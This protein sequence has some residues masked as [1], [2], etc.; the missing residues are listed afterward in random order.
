MLLYGYIIPRYDILEAELEMTSADQS[1]KSVK[2]R[3]NICPLTMAK[4]FSIIVVIFFFSIVLL[5]IG[6][7]EIS[8]SPSGIDPT[9]ITRLELNE[10]GDFFAGIGGTLA[11]VWLITSTILQRAELAENRRE[12]E[13]QNKELNNQTKALTDV[14]RAMSDQE[15]AMR[16][17][18]EFLSAQTN[19]LPDQIKAFS[20]QANALKIQ[21]KILEDT[22]QNNL[23]DRAWQ[24]IK[25][26]L[27]II[28]EKI[29]VNND[30]YFWKIS[31]RDEDSV[32]HKKIAFCYTPKDPNDLEKCSDAQFLYRAAGA[33]RTA[34]QPLKKPESYHIIEKRSG[35][36]LFISLQDCFKQI[37]ALSETVS[38]QRKAQIQQCRISEW[39][40]LLNVAISSYDAMSKDGK[41]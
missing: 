40:D 29:P 27:A 6:L 3:M 17:Q 1:K 33:L 19:S 2:R 38:P 4:A 20:E 22:W 14:S 5:K 11:L 24:D 37:D 7:V 16:K 23:E 15:K 12:L 26:L 10:W 30:Y 9:P 13:K 36:N 31:P 32:D 41:K 34:V 39:Y 21:T 18:V 8:Y 35:K 28:R 25:D